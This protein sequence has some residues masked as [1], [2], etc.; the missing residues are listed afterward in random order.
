MDIEARSFQGF[1]IFG[2]GVAQPAVDQ[3]RVEIE[4]VLEKH[5]VTA[6]DMQRLTEVFAD[7]ASSGVD[8]Q[9]LGSSDWKRYGVDPK[10]V[11]ANR[12]LHE[13]LKAARKDGSTSPG[14][15]ISF[16]ATPVHA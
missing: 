13:V 10:H 11:K 2:R 9:Q 14:S 15:V 7:L 12:H 8:L 6:A 5:G 4:G 16:K 3:A 1:S